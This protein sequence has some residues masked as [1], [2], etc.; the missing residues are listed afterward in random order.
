MPENLN[1]KNN[2]A[3]QKDTNAKIDAIKIM[4]NNSDYCKKM[5]QKLTDYIKENK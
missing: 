5:A 2:K 3:K 1:D 4:L